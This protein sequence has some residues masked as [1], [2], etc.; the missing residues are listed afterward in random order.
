MTVT[1]ANSSSDVKST[2]VS[3]PLCRAGTLAFY[4]S[5][6]DAYLVRVL[7]EGYATASKQLTDGLSSPN[8]AGMLSA[9]SDG[10]RGNS[11][12]AIIAEGT[13]HSHDV[14]YFPGDGT[15]GPYYLE[16]ANLIGPFPG[17]G[18]DKNIVEVDEVAFIP[19]YTAG[20]LI[21]GSVFIDIVNG[22]LTFYVSDAPTAYSQITVNIAYHTAKLTVV[23]GN[24]VYPAIDNLSDQAAIQAALSS[25]GLL[26]YTSDP[27]IT[28]LPASGTYS[29][30]GGD[31]GAAITSNDWDNAILA[32]R[33]YI[34]E[35][36]T[37]ITAITLTQTSVDEGDGSYDLFS[38][39]EGH[40]AEMEQDWEPCLWVLGA[41]ENAD[42][43]D[44]IQ[45]VSP[46]AHRNLIFVANPWGAERDPPRTNGW[47]ALAAREAQITLGDDT[48]ERSSLNAI[49]GMQGLLNPLRKAT[50]R[51]LQNNRIT[52][53]VKENA[54]IFPNWSRTLGIDQQFADSVDNRTVNYI[55]RML[56][57]ISKQFYF[58]KNIPSVR[59]DLRTSIAQQLN[60]LLEQYVAVK[61]ILEVRGPGDKG[62]AYTDN[63]RIDIDLQ[64][65]NVGHIKRIMINYGVGIIE[66]GSNV[67]Y[68]PNIFSQS[69]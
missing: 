51:G 50:V 23:D 25:N 10:A 44:L 47:V 65:E 27:I 64:V 58:K 69:D 56:Y 49:M 26:H 60:Q 34:A 61:Y 67:V 36:Q 5:L 40:C 37:G 38:L 16:F 41:D 14:E 57:A 45:I 48:G 29:L 7:G 22:S 8:N 32:L 24:T 3:G 33:D 55:L 2:Y 43:S 68:A 11:V 39:A 17:T 66:D 53:L 21:A 15:V 6:Q 62:Y 18:T 12:K 19:V 28:H 54:A 42:A 35:A 20:A 1:T 52:C 4:N 59:E 63:S 9:A 46:H 30:V 31:D 13:F